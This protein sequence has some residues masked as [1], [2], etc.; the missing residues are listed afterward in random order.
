MNESTQRQQTVQKKKEENTQDDH[1]KHM[2]DI[3]VESAQTNEIQEPNPTPRVIIKRVQLV[4][5]WSYETRNDSDN[6]AICTNELIQ[7]CLTTCEV[8]P[9]FQEECSVAT[10]ACNHVYH[11]HCISNWMRKRS[12]CPLCD[13]EWEFIK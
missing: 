5:S 1:I 11:F 2:Q 6:C 10:G 3:I 4:A 12:S 7:P 9:Q 13:E 8:N